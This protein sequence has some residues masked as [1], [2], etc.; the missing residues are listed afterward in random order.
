MAGRLERWFSVARWVAVFW[1]EGG[2]GVVCQQV[3]HHGFY[4]PVEEG[5]NGSRLPRR[6][7]GATARAEHHWWSGG[8]GRRLG[9]GDTQISGHW[10]CGIWECGRSPMSRARV[11]GEGA[12]VVASWQGVAGLHRQVG[13][14]DMAVAHTVGGRA[15]VGIR[16]PLSGEDALPERQG[17]ARGLV[18]RRAGTSCP[19]TAGGCPE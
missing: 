15:R 17:C 7:F 3:S 1:A 11:G 19:F 12:R 4:R 16:R 10:P 5:G 13:S 2:G 9:G 18:G 8:Q 6:S 14:D